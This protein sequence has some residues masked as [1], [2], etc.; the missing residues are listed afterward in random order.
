MKYKVNEIFLSLQGEGFNQGK[1]VIFIRLA[2]CNLNCKWCDTCYEN[3]TNYSDSEIIDEISKF[4]CKS[5]IITGGEPTIHNLE[6]LLEKLKQKNYWIGIE[7]NGTIE[8]E[9]LK[10]QLDYITISPK[11]VA[12]QK[13]AN[14]VR[15]VNDKVSV[16]YLQ[17]IE[18]SLNADNY[19]I[20]PL[21]ENNDMNIVSTLKLLKDINSQSKKQWRLSL[22]LHKIFGIK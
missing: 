19:Y 8:I 1:K 7:T 2:G 18:N 15:I 3:F 20:S 11:G 9:H 13:N 4:N 14:E 10:A 12:A 22:Q 6:N 16:G 5:V 17:T 21:D